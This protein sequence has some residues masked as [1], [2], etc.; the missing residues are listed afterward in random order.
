MWHRWETIAGYARLGDQ[1]EAQTSHMAH[2]PLRAPSPHTWCTAPLRAPF[3]RCTAEPVHHLWDPGAA[4]P[5]QC[6]DPPCTFGYGHKRVVPVPF[7]GVAHTAVSGAGINL[8][9]QVRVS[10]LC[11]CR[12]LSVT[13]FYCL[14]PSVTVCC[15]CASRPSAA[16]ASC[17][18]SERGRAS[19]PRR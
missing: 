17:A 8:G 9:L 10:P 6:T 18:T 4:E 13:V 19:T 16:K 1:G 15:R 7:Y 11:D 5:A 14:L 12:L 3:P 2:C